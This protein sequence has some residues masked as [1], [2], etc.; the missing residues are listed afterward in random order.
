MKTYSF[1]VVVRLDEDAQGDP[2]WHAYCPALDSVDAATSGRTRE[3]ALSNI[4]HAVRMIVREFPKSLHHD[5]PSIDAM[6]SS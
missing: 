1:K 6:M 2:A 4:N 3:E 5:A